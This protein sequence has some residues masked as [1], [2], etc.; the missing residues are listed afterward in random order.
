MVTSTSLSNTRWGHL[1]DQG[2]GGRW[3][4]QYCVSTSILTCSTTSYLVKHHGCTVLH[5]HY[6]HSTNDI[7]TIS[8]DMIFKICTACYRWHNILVIGK[9]PSPFPLCLLSMAPKLFPTLSE[10]KATIDRAVQEAL[11][12]HAPRVAPLPVEPLSHP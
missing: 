4:W 12:R 9:N 3:P 6:T 2:L 11:A 5:M 7:P 10:F 8:M 1:P